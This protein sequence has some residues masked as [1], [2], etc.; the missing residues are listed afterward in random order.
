MRIRLAFLLLIAASATWADLPAACRQGAVFDDRNGNARRDPGENGIPGVLVSDGIELARS[1]GDGRYR[2]RNDAGRAVFVIKP[3]GHAVALR[4]DGL[5]DHWRA[6]AAAAQAARCDFALQ[7]A[8]D[9]EAGL[10]VLVFADPQVQSDVDVGHYEHDIIEPILGEGGRLPRAA[11]TGVADL[12]ITLGDIVARGRTSLYPALD[13]ATAR[14]AT[15]WLHVPGNHDMDAHATTD[16]GA[17]GAFSRHYGPDTFAWE[18][19]NATFVLIDNVVRL[20]GPSASYIGGLREDQFGFL[21]RYL[22]TVPVER[23]L[24]IATH[25]PL[26]DTAPD[27][28]TFRRADRR[29][30]F[31][32]L[33][34]FPRRLVLSGHTHSQRHHFH[35]ASTGWLGKTPLHEY[36]VGAASGAFWSGVRDAT[37][38][39]DA[40]MGDGTP[41]GHA[42]LRV[43]AD[44]GYRLG[45]HPAR[46]QPGDPARTAAMHLHAPKILRRGA[47]PAWGIYANVYMG[48]ADTRVEYRVDGGEW[49][50]MRR[51]ERPD[52]KLLIENVADDQAPSLR[53]YDRSPEATP[54]PHLWRGA[55]PTDLAAGAHRVEVRAFDT[56]LGEQ[57]AW[58]EYRL[59]DASP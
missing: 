15:P 17:L 38:I 40:T 41:N 32:L 49:R 52:P 24:V 8:H 5:P 26:F 18:E 53:G 30:L 58:I 27:R 6:P 16:A 29:R 23:L 9:N 11:G 7:R 3:A 10:D 13:A 37:G 59:D 43:G 14:L 25:I 21:E 51:V 50:P 44:G 48:H 2:L 55:L 56:W 39:P 57:R 19:T 45:W 28:E 42:R 12:G 33:E 54:S 35:D 46:L 31:A 47:Y 36:N 4:P 20:P 22:A 1:D 34:R